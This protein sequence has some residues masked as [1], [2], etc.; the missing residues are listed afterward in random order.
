MPAMVAVNM[1]QQRGWEDLKLLREANIE[2]EIIGQ[3]NVVPA[4]TEASGLILGGPMSV[5]ADR[6]LVCGRRCN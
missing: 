1:F 4:I 5:Y 6:Y 2:I 3:A